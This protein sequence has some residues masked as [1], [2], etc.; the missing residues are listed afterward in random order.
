MPKTLRG[1]LCKNAEFDLTKL[2]FV[3]CGIVRSSWAF[4][5]SS[6]AFVVSRFAV[7]LQRSNPVIGNFLRTFVN[8]KLKRLLVIGTAGQSLDGLNGSV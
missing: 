6:W 8:C 7:L 3:F 2:Y 5:V 4:V 1:L